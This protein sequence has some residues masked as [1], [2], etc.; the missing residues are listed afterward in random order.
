[1][2]NFILS[3]REVLMLR[4]F[5]M[6]NGDKVYASLSPGTAANQ[7]TFSVI[8]AHGIVISS[9][10]FA[11]SGTGNQY[12]Q[13]LDTGS[14]SSSS[15]SHSQLPISILHPIQQGLWRVER[16]HGARR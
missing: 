12:F 11:Y 14:C 5:K 10:S 1:M 3:N 7:L 16:L 2:V 15:H 9:N 6:T 8:D 4:T 13:H